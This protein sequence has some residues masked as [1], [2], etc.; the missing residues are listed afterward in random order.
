MWLDPS[1]TGSV[2]RVYVT[3]GGGEWV[4]TTSSRSE[5]ALQKGNGVTANTLNQIELIDTG[6]F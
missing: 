2:L 4:E 1:G 3:A 6:S 5:T